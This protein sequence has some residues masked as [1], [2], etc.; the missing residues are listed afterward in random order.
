MIPEQRD[1]SLESGQ[2]TRRAQKG[3]NH[4]L[5]FCWCLVMI[6]ITPFSAASSSSTDSSIQTTTSSN[7]L[8]LQDSG[9]IYEN[10]EDD[11][12]D[13]LLSDYDHSLDLLADLEEED[14]GEQSVDDEFVVANK[15][16][17]QSSSHNGST[18][19][20]PQFHNRHSKSSTSRNEEEKDSVIILSAV[21]GTL[22]GISRTS[23]QMLWK[24]S[25]RVDDPKEKVAKEKQKKTEQD[26]DKVLPVLPAE[27]NKFLSPLVSSSMTKSPSST[28]KHNSYYQW[29]AV[30]SVDGT[31]Y[32]T[33][34]DGTTSDASTS[35][36]LSVSTHI[37][38]LVDRAP[39]V[40]AQQRFFVGSR[41]A[42]VA[43]VDERTGE[44][45][46]VIPKWNTNND[47]NEKGE[48]EEDNDDEQLPPTL[49]GRDVV[50]IGRLEHSVTVH[51]L[52]KGTVDIEF[53]VAEILS[54]DE[55]IHGESSRQSTPS[56]VVFRDEDGDGDNEDTDI[57]ATQVEQE[58]ERLFTDYIT[59][60]L[61]HPNFGDRILRLPAPDESAGEDTE[62]IYADARA[63][64]PSMSQGSAF[65]VSTPSG[66]VAFRDDSDSS[67]V[68]WVSFELLDS[69]VIYAIEASSGRKI[70][71]NMLDDSSVS[72]ATARSS[73]E[74][75]TSLPQLLEQQ[76]ASLERSSSSSLSGG[77][78]MDEACLGGKSGECRAVGFSRQ[79]SV[80]GALQ[81]GQIYAL[82]LGERIISRPQLPLGLPQ[83]HSSAASEM[84]NAQ[85]GYQKSKL[86]TQH[87]SIGFHEH[88]YDP[89][90]D[91]D[92]GDKQQIHLDANTKQS[93]TPASPLYPGCLIGASLMM[94]NLLDVNGNVDMASL[95]DYIDLLE[96]NS[97]KKSTY[98][99][100]FIKIM[101]SW[102]APTVALIFVLSFEMG[103]RERLKAEAS[104]NNS[105]AISGDGISTDK[106]A[107]DAQNN[108]STNNQGGVIQLSEE[109]LGYG[110]HGTIVY[111]GVLDK[112]QVAV[113][114]MLAMYHASADREISL[115][116]E[117]DGHPNVVRYF[118][119]E[120]RGDF[121]CKYNPLLVP[122]SYD[123]QQ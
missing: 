31:V 107:K 81:N 90:D 4:L 57:A 45:L 122:C 52:H 123:V 73:K 82:P 36:E 13:I 51:D 87:A 3:K 108:N 68:G 91:V 50:W 78:I 14:E 22:A 30:P 119:K 40:D 99:Q 113:K 66:N 58:M 67:T 39:F 121:V 76:I 34:G 1:L 74:D 19:D 109:I 80:V 103:R 106:S 72:S 63:G 29:Q 49:E 97:R 62:D 8:I 6:I 38:D 59:E 104:K 89:S 23:G 69:P 94:G 18:K 112:R 77:S 55:M 27:W 25:R 28:E 93:C 88:R 110:G 105:D 7:N 35:H 10:D 53:S 42:M 26:D 15:L 65:L 11:M 43:A 64:G 33:G 5:L 115:L 71:V 47:G 24:Q 83:P 92:S 96:G 75:P 21:D 32:L 44:I 56:S 86:N 79:G 16:K 70:R 98:F 102:I 95:S 17:I 111:K 37:R 2:S 118:L 12:E 9:I 100:H 48:D 101:S 20:K 120:M 46:R 61:R 117:S 41:R 116:I 60:A 114:R 85:R 84:S 54:V